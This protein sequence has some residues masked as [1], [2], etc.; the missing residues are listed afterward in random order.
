MQLLLIITCLLQ[1]SADGW[2][3]LTPSA[4]SRTIYVSSSVGDDAND[5]LSE[6]AP[7]KTIRSAIAVTK[8]GRPDW[9]LLKRGDVFTEGVLAWEKS[10]RSATER[11][12]LTAYGVGSRPVLNETAFL[13][14]GPNAGP[15]H[16]LQNIAF[17]DLDFKASS[18]I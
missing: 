3:V 10:G 12:V 13:Y 14:W 17:L 4:D 7:K 1:V 16:V 18:H 9:I 6:A 15:T 2:T 11:M 8:D 5:G